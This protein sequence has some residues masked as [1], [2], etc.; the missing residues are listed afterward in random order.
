MSLGCGKSWLGW[1]SLREAGEG[2]PPKRL[3]WTRLALRPLLRF[4][5][6]MKIPM[7]QNEALDADNAA[8]QLLGQNQDPGLSSQACY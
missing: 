6:F 7:R 5:E 4:A 8:S 1:P 3:S 2:S